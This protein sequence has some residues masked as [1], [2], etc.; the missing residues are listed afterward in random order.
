[1]AENGILNIEILSTEVESLLVREE[2]SR[3]TN[4]GT[5]KEIALDDTTGWKDLEVK[6]IQLQQQILSIDLLAL[7]LK[8][9]ELIVSKAGVHINRHIRQCTQ[10]FIEKLITQHYLNKTRDIDQTTYR[11]NLYKLIYHIICSG[12]D[13][14]WCEIKLASCKASRAFLLSLT[15]EERKLYWS[16]LLPQLCMN[17]FYTAEGVKQYSHETWRIVIQTQGKVLITEYIS[18]IIQHYIHMSK[19][20][21][22]MVCEASCH[23]LSEIISKIASTVVSPYIPV[24]T[25]AIL[26]CLSD[27]SWPVRDAAC[28][29]T[30]V[31]LK[32]YPI[33]LSEYMST[34]YPILEAQLK[35]SIWSV[36]ENAAIAIS[37]GISCTTTDTDNNTG[38][39]TGMKAKLLIFTRNYLEANMNEAEQEPSIEEVKNSRIVS[40]LPTELLEKAKLSPTSSSTQQ[41]TDPTCSVPAASVSTLIA[42][43]TGPDKTISTTNTVAPSPVVWRTGGGWGCCLDCIKERRVSPWEASAGCIVLLRELLLLLLLEED[44]EEI[45]NS[46]L[47][48]TQTNRAHSISGSDDSKRSKVIDIDPTV[49]T[50]VSSLFVRMVDLLKLTHFKDCDKLHTLVITHIS[51]YQSILQYISM[52]MCY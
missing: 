13:E 4:L 27:P 18:D 50:W 5:E 12:L 20:Q 51:L 21:N 45:Y 42:A 16:G 30:A 28:V 34:I 2:I 38:C 32:H 48:H 19:A 46:N 44:Q 26:S 10:V 47:T 15:Q 14:N 25:T 9:F 35:D 11:N 37:D 52:Y 31:L 40:F 41:P 33:H 22:H 49:L 23:A 8:L 43:T 36:R 39:Y 6:L 17:R 7:D 3:P 29:T 24:I 1:M